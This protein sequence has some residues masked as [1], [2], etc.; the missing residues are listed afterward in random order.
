M[1]RQDDKTTEDTEIPFVRRSSRKKV[2]TALYGQGS[3]SLSS[4]SSTQ[5]E[6]QEQSEETSEHKETEV[7]DNSPE[8]GDSSDS[9]NVPLS[10]FSPGKGRKRSAKSLKR[11]PSAK[12]TKGTPSRTKGRISFEHSD[13]HSSMFDIIKGG[14]G[15]LQTVVD[16]WI[17]SYNE[18]RTSAMVD[19]IHFIIQC[20]GCKGVVTEKMLEEEENVNAI[21]KLTEEFD[22][23]THEYPLTMSGQAYKKFKTNFCEF[24]DCLIQ[25]CQHSIVYD[26][27]MMEKLISWLI[28]LSDSQVR[29]F[30]HT[31][32]LAGMKLVAALI[33]VAVK[34]NVELDN[35]QRQLDSEKQKTAS[36]RG[37]QKMEMLQNKK[38][39]LRENIRELEEFMSFIFQ[40]IFV[41]RYRDIRPEIRSLCISEIGCWMKDYSSVFLS[42]KYLKYVVWTLHDKVGDVRLHALQSL[43]RLYKVEEFLP[44]LEPLTSRFKGRIVAMTLDKE[45]DVTAEAIK[46]VTL[47]FRYGELDEEDCQQVEQ[48]VFCSHRQVSHEAGYFL[49]ERLLAEAESASPSKRRASKKSEFQK[50]CEYMKRLIDFFISTQIHN[51]ASYLVDS[52]WEHCDILKDWKVMTSML[53]EDT[54][55][56]DL[57]D[58]EETALIEIMTCC[59]RQA[60]LGQGP[61]GRAVKRLLSTKEKKTI[62][63]DKQ[64]M[65]AHFMVKL[66]AL[67]GKYGTDLP[68]AENLVTIPQYFDLEEYTQRR[69]GKYFEDLLDQI[70]D[71]VQK[72]P[73]MP[74]LEECAKTYRTLTDNELTLRSKAE[75]S[76]NKLMDNVVELFKD[77]IKN[78]AADKEDQN[79]E[80]FPADA[81]AVEVNLK[82]ITA[83]YKSHDLGPWDLYEALRAIIR[84]E[85]A[86]AEVISLALVSL[87]MLLIWSLHALDSNRPS[88]REMKTLKQRLSDF[89]RVTADFLQF[90]PE[91]VPKQAFL[92]LC[93][94]LIVFAKQLKNH[95]PQFTPLIYET[96]RDVQNRCRDY[97][98]TYVFADLNEDEEKEDEDNTENEVEELNSK[99]VILAG[100][101]KFIAYDVFDMKLAT[102]VF[103]HIIT[104]FGNFGDII[105]H[106]MAKCREINK[107]GYTKTIA[108]TLEQAFESY[109]DKEGSPIDRTSEDFVATK[110]LAKRLS[111]TFGIDSTKSNVRNSMVTLHREAILFSFRTNGDDSD[112]PSNALPNLPFLDVIN[113]CTYRLIPQD[114]KVVLKYLQDQATKAEIDLNKIDANLEP[115]SSYYNALNDESQ[116][117]GG[118]TD[119]AG[120]GRQLP[121]KAKRKLVVDGEANQGKLNKKTDLQNKNEEQDE[122][123]EEEVEEN[124]S[125][126]KLNRKNASKTNTKRKRGEDVQSDN[127]ADE[128]AEPN[129]EDDFQ[130]SSSGKASSQVSWISSQPKRSAKEGRVSYGKAK[131]NSRKGA[132]LEETVDEK[133]REEEDDEREDQEV[134]STESASPKSTPPPLKRTRTDLPEG[135]FEESPAKDTQSDDDLASAF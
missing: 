45:N 113:E 28:S 92:C 82:R 100:F 66:P 48:L 53:L 63:N 84:N 29:A 5:Q 67:L 86:A 80:E 26:D 30:R 130:G 75:V 99:R 123:E 111:L 94:I 127:S 81:Y 68:K 50:K 91:D 16:D 104:G 87:E 119:K 13:G 79:E 97:V 19:L 62:V 54:S 46:L 11:L 10:H 71:L 9:D 121:Q 69:L 27:F 118:K 8:P 22:E 109:R 89:I 59:C 115:L 7:T 122:E 78:F 43:L 20:C 96:S 3:P 103:S 85:K 108:L 61:P 24:I 6:S 40:G 12:K 65:S 42:H 112:A 60:A 106:T 88:K 2:Q 131:S 39:Q 116:A 129:S 120:R 47:L 101:C 52:I 134:K 76:R 25:Q 36:K 90:G 57:R 49:H 56:E 14:K 83:F 95:Y 38:E 117:A 37:V 133:E 58:E 77:G 44:Q 21:R 55:A 64:E 72:G 98:T 32:T 31:S 23:E 124:E 33:Q 125:L 132:S 70:D 102:T 74:L 41:H 128:E 18:D 110:D 73:E 107:K 93:D 114:K 35:T 15:A 34:V 135:I 1:D 51:H 17:E 4:P 126:S 105:K